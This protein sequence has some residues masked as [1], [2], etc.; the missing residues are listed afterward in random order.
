MAYDYDDE[1]RALQ[2]QIDKLSNQVNE[3]HRPAPRVCMDHDFQKLQEAHDDLTEA[4]KGL[5]KVVKRQAAAI[6]EL[7]LG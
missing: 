7:S 2:R 1:F 3:P 6:E 4:F 5:V